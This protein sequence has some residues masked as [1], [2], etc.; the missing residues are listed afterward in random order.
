MRGSKKFIAVLVILLSAVM[1]LSSCDDKA[2]APS[3]EYMMLS[4]S[5]GK[6]HTLPKNARVVCAYGSFAECWILSGG[7]LVGVTEDAV[8]ERGL[9][10]GEGVDII[11]SVK[12][13]DLELVIA[14]KPDF[15]ILSADLTAHCQLE[16]QLS[17]RGI[18]S[19]LFRIDSFEDYSR[20][21]REFCNFNG[22]EELYARHVS[23]VEKRINSIRASIPKEGEPK[24]ALIMRAYSNGIKVKTDTLAED[25]V[26]ELGCV[27]IAEKYPSLLTD[28]SVEQIV[29]SDPDYILVLTMGDE[30]KAAAYLEKYVAENPALSELSAVKNGRMIILPKELFHYKPNN[31]WDES[32]EFLAKILY[33]E[34]FE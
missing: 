8:S 1:L 22:G 11:G 30:D 34:Q 12:S 14:L 5:E 23:E 25:I 16:R 24:T 18:E 26:R 17:D 33:P 4:D 32:Y 28:L 9:E 13:V 21:M 20:V 29:L 3:G 31:K 27:S 7:R 10:L 6:V 2:P 15:V 19:G